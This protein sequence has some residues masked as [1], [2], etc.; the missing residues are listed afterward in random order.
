MKKI[1]FVLL[2]II[3]F[4]TVKV[5]IASALV[6]TSY[7]V[8]A[9]GEWM[10]TNS[11]NA[12]E[13]SPAGALAPL[14][15]QINNWFTSK[16]YVYQVTLSYY[17]KATPGDGD[18]GGFSATYFS[19]AGAEVRAYYYGAWSSTLPVEFYAVKAGNSYALW[20][21]AGR[22][23]TGYW[24]TE[25]L[26]VG[27]SNNPQTPDV[28]HIAS[29]NSGAAVPEPA[30]MLLFGTGLIGLAGIARRKVR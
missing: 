25:H 19:V 9:S 26:A 7:P 11:G 23:S 3:S 22:A 17:D 5:E 21:V 30:T 2:A 6:V 29:Y 12:P 27:N 24:T 13:S 4:G 28:S 1:F 8:T 18:F 16:G 20:W 15:E 10:F 14:E